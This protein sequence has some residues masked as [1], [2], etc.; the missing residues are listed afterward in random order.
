MHTDLEIVKINFPD[1]CFEKRLFNWGKMQASLPN[2]FEI[3]IKEAFDRSAVQ[4]NACL[5]DRDLSPRSPWL[6]EP[7][8]ISGKTKED[9]A[10]QILKKIRSENVSRLLVKPDNLILPERNVSYFPLRNSDPFH[11]HGALEFFDFS[12]IYC[13]SSEDPDGEFEFLKGFAS[14]MFG[15]AVI[16]EDEIG[17]PIDE[18]ILFEVNYEENHSHFVSAET[19]AEKLSL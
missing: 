9:C 2:V 18:V 14:K 15:E 7:L 8:T 1:I 10:V 16:F 3:L 5:V 13:R 11:A 19:L 6:L 12:P 17:A 4:A